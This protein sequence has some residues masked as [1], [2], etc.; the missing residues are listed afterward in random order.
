M[1]S[2]NLAASDVYKLLWTNEIL[3]MIPTLAKAIEVYT[4][5]PA[6]GQERLSSLALLHIEREFV[7]RVIVEDMSR[8][9]DIFGERSGRNALFF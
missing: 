9:I 7:N 2:G 1:S 4:V 5:I 6:M 3:P 8:M